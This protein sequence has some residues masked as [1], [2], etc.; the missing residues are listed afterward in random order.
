MSERVRSR[1]CF[2]SS[3]DQVKRSTDRAI[4]FCDTFLIEQ[5]A[6]SIALLLSS[7]PFLFKSSSWPIASLLF[8]IHFC[9]SQALGRLRFTP[10]RQKHPLWFVLSQIQLFSLTTTTI[11][12]QDTRPAR[13]RSCHA[14][15]TVVV[16]NAP[17]AAK[18]A[19]TK[20]VF[21]TAAAERTVR[22]LPRRSARKQTTTTRVVA[23][24]RLRARPRAVSSSV[25]RVMFLF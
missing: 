23:V 3:F 6:W 8:V 4:A 5:G 22:R 16:Y 1:R 14:P 7:I 20:S 17:P 9:S 11:S 12:D 18:T 10:N 25:S 21:I 13:S 24:A 2:L 19:A 15:V